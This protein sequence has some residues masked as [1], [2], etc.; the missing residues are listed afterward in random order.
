MG[1]DIGVFVLR[2]AFYARHIGLHNIEMRGCGARRFRNDGAGS[3]NR[4][5]KT[6]VS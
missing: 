6:G 1:F 3:G 5:V 4:A 2:G